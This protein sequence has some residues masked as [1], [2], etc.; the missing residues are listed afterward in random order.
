MSQ[1][2]MTADQ[3]VVVI[4]LLAN[5]IRKLQRDGRPDPMQPDLTR[6]AGSRRRAGATEQYIRGMVDVLAV[7]FEGGRP[8]AEECYEEARRI[9]LDPQPPGSSRPD[10]N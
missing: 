8:Y 9:A 3:R 7:L 10:L 4:A 6:L 1:P 2:K 5:A